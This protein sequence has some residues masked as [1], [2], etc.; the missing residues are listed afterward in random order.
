ME[1]LNAQNPNNW[2]GIFYLNR[3]DSRVMVPK[4]NPALG[5]TFNL[6]NPMTWLGIATIFAI[7]IISAWLF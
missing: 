3:N 1:D 5:W 7:A 6:A 4:Q 2:R